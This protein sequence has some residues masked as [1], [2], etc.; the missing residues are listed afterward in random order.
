MEKN[1]KLIQW[2]VLPALFIVAILGWWFPILGFFVLGCMMAPLIVSAITKKRVW[3]GYYCPRGALSDQILK[4]IT[5]K[6]R[7]VP[8]WM[9]SK[10]LR[11]IIIVFMFSFVGYKV[12]S[13]W[14][15]PLKIAGFFV[16]ML[17][18]TTA[19]A[20]ILAVFH[21]RGWCNICP[22]GTLS[23]VI[24]SSDKK[25]EVD[26]DACVSCNLCQKA[27]P[28]AIKPYEDEDHSECLTCYE[29]VNACPKKAI[30]K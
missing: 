29:C 11:T 8:K 19:I 7:I 9:K 24:S 17:C 4:H 12:Y 25:V 27:C 18:V 20:F 15:D 1:K 10:I 23:N 30:K 14:G 21:Y 28:V 5:P 3:C 16:L 26:K 22:M 2:I 6:N 13:L